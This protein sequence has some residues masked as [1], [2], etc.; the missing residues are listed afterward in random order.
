[1]GKI[2]IIIF[3]VCVLFPISIYILYISIY[4]QVYIYIYY[5]IYIIQTFPLRKITKCSPKTMEHSRYGG[6]VKILS[7][8]KYNQAIGT[9][10]LNRISQN[11]CKAK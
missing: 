7:V 4:F 8:E 2:P 3:Y 11:I 10:L 1:M 5:C 9:N 6:S